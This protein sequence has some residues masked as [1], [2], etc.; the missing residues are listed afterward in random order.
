MAEKLLTEAQL[1]RATDLVYAREQIEE[2]LAIRRASKA[3]QKKY[4]EGHKLR[5]AA[6]VQIAITDANRPQS[7]SDE[8]CQT[9][10]YWYLS[11][12]VLERALRAELE[13][14]KADIKALGIIP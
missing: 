10:A 9:I 6:V 7:A 14:V 4:Y 2:F 5:K 13:L 11:R 8:E 12:N 1:H 3:E